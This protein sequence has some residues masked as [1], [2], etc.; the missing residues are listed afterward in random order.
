LVSL[1]K[2]FPRFNGGQTAGRESKKWQKSAHSRSSRA[3]RS[4]RVPAADQLRGPEAAQ[5]QSLRF[6]QRGTKS[7]AGVSAWCG[8]RSGSAERQ[9]HR[10]R[11]R[12]SRLRKDTPSRQHNSQQTPSQRQIAAV[13]ASIRRVKR[14]CPKRVYGASTP[15]YSATTKMTGGQAYVQGETYRRRERCHSRPTIASQRRRTAAMR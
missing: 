9:T 15:R 1:A 14:R 5:E 6:Q 7:V 2:A 4:D 3:H 11:R 10:T 13:Q 12:P 8:W